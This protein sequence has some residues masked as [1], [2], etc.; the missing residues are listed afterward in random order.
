MT[1]K[2]AG[3]DPQ[4]RMVQI[5]SRAAYGFIQFRSKRLEQQARAA[6]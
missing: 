5:L 6:A 3:L 4:S 2:A 1:F